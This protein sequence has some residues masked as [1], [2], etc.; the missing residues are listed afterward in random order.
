M[1]GVDNRTGKEIRLIQQTTSTWRSNKTLLWLNPEKDDLTQLWNRIDIGVIG[2]KNY[3][4]L[5]ENNI[6]ADVILCTQLEDASWISNGGFDKVN[7]IFASKEVLDIIGLKYFEDNN[8]RNILCLE[9]L[10]LLYSFLENKWDRTINDACI[11]IA[12]I[13]RFSSVYGSNCKTNTKRTLYNLNIYS[14]LPVLPQLYFITQYYVPTQ[15]KRA[16]EINMALKKNIENQYIDKIILFNEEE[17][18]LPK[19]NKIQQIV[20]KKRLYYDDVLRYIYNSV[21]DNVIVVFANSDIYLDNTIRHVWSTN[22]DNIFMALLRYENDVIFGPR[23]DSQDTWILTSNSVKQRK[24]KYEDFNFSFGKSGCDNAITLEMLRMKYLIV[25]PA[26]TIKTHHLHDSDIRTYDKQDIVNKNI[27]LYIEPTGLHDL[28]AITNIPKENIERILT[29]EEINRPINCNNTNKSATYC[30]MLEKE[31]RYSYGISSQNTVTK[32]S[33][34]IYKFNNIF[35]TN[36]GLIYSYNKIFVGASKIANKYWSESNISTLAP[37]I[38]VKKGYIAPLPS[39]YVNSRELYLLYYLPKILLLR[40][41]YGNDG[42]FWCPNNKEFIEAMYLFQWNTKNMPLL[43][44]SDNETAFINE[45]YVWF[46]SDNLEV[47]SEEMN[48]LRSFLKPSVEEECVLVF[49]DEEYITKDFIKDLENIYTNVK[50]VFKSTSLD[51]KISLL[52]SASACILYCSEKT[53]YAWRYVWAMKQNTNIITIQNEMEMNGEIHHIASSSTLKH[54][55]HIVP[56]GSIA[57]STR[58]KI[59]DSL[60]INSTQSNIPTIY[61]PRSTSG[62]FQHS[63]DSF[64]E[65]IDLWAE[66]GYVKKEY[67]SCKNVWLNGIGN[68]L[69]YDR[70]NYDW[71]KNADGNEQ[72][73]KHGLFGNP[74]PLGPKSVAW[75]FWPRR[76][77]LVE[78]MLSKDFKKTKGIVFYGCTENHVQKSNRTKHDWSSCCDEF[79]MT[80]KPKFSQQ[81]YLDNLA[82]AKYGLCLAGYGYKCHRE[83]ECMAFGT[84]PLVAPEVDMNSYANP[85]VEGLHYIRVKDPEYLKDKLNQ[86]DDDVWWRMSE[87]CKVWYK[88]NCSVDGIWLLTKKLLKDKID[89]LN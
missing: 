86:F 3:E 62:F 55:L 29:F 83:V 7:I 40:N 67:S 20:I 45:A 74:A 49:M 57:V 19:T 26:L 85:P 38:K 35:Q 88:E 78:A 15:N 75:S 73:W 48:V 13:L 59:I 36:H 70:P 9:E 14:G 56:K 10:H 52:Q 68:I 60:I 64:R 41:L 4:L 77:R 6:N 24:W 72:I 50:V 46:P 32:V 2:S 33:M 21:P 76:P 53:E 1:Y 42:E 84:V 37:N 81:E 43:S 87:A 25:N 82:S 28:E 23:P 16:K 44:Q 61:V 18:V 89:F 65:M 80:E 63:G 39:E 22:I 5:L 51:R 11:C 17:Y 69:L 79:V 58:K 54:T 31:K 34:P 66:K 12:L 27:Y 71:I 30:K 47:S 8:I